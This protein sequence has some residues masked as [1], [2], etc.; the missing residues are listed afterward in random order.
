MIEELSE[1]LI[2]NTLSLWTKKIMSIGRLAKKMHPERANM[3]HTF[4]VEAVK[5]IEG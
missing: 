2:R 3:S 1:S 5:C 4:V